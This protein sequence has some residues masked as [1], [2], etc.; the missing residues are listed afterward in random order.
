[1]KVDLNRAQ[2][3]L[4]EVEQRY[5]RNHPAY[6]SSAAQVKSLQSKLTAEIQVAKGSIS[7]TAEIAE[8]RASQLQA[9]VEA[10][11]TRILDLKRR[12]DQLDVLNHDVATA[13]H[14][15]DAAAQR[16]SEVRLQGRLDQSNIAI[17]NPA[18]PALKPW[19]PK[20][21]LNLLVGLV[22]G[23]AF[24]VA[25]VL[26]AELRNRRVRSRDDLVN[27]TGVLVLVEMPRLANRPRRRALRSRARRLEQLDAPAGV[28]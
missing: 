12:H 7:Q 10:Q 4:A 25:A 26:A 14:G 9:A 15:Y 27:S 24:A 2:G 22:L 20:L 11:K 13:Q 18:V 21:W 23:T 5:G 17:L 6:I 8:R 3:N 1:M 28:A 19:R 16:A